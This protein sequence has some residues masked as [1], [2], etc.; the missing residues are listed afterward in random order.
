MSGEFLSNPGEHEARIKD[1][2]SRREELVAEM[3]RVN[4]E[5]E[6]LQSEAG[7][8]GVSLREML[9][10]SEKLA[11]DEKVFSLL[12]RLDTD[13]D[14]QNMIAESRLMQDEFDIL[15]IRAEGTQE[16]VGVIKKELSTYLHECKPG[17]TYLD[18]DES[19]IATRIKADPTI[20][21][22]DK[23]RVLRSTI[24]EVDKLPEVKSSHVHNRDQEVN[25]A[26]DNLRRNFHLGL[27]QNYTLR[28]VKL[29]LEIDEK[30]S[31]VNKVKRRE[32]FDIG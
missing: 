19:P 11:N 5:L 16:K 10:G 9:E 21:F 12:K 25:S 20:I 31:G 26:V 24:I 1:L 27:E 13:T 30:L 3:A 18:A 22:I 8:K 17:D 15:A 23:N 7:E 32:N 4:K 6:G 14:L 29:L 28:I 2:L